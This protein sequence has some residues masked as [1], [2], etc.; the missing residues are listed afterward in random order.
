MRDAQEA[1]PEPPQEDP[2]TRLARVKKLQAIK[3]RAEAAPGSPLHPRTADLVTR[4]GRVLVAVPKPHK[5]ILGLATIADC[6]ALGGRMRG[7]KK[8]KTPEQRAA[9]LRRIGKKGAR[10]RAKKR[11]A[12]RKAMDR[13]DRQIARDRAALLKAGVPVS[14][15]E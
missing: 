3:A 11:Q 8:W 6:A 2:A 5:P 7:S 13:L 9:G 15:L 14:E 10:A 1:T 12:L 4:R